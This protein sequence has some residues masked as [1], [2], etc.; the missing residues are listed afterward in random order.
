[1]E[2]SAHELCKD[3]SRLP[4][5]HVFGR[6]CLL[7]WLKP[8][9]EGG[10]GNSCP[11]CRKKL[12]TRP[13]NSGDTLDLIGLSPAGS[14]SLQVPPPTALQSP[15]L[16]AID[17]LGDFTLEHPH[18]RSRAPEAI[19]PREFEHFNTQENYLIDDLEVDYD[20]RPTQRRLEARRRGLRVYV[21][22]LDALQL[23]LDQLDFGRR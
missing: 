8:A 9:P 10:N 14:L 18:G 7:I 22:E 11:T 6:E 19:E 13:H 23:Q 5:G 20:E 4:C 21:R 12:F 3:P 2:K 15:T 17:A 1:M 16:P